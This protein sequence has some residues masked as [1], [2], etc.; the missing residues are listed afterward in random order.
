[1]DTAGKDHVDW[2]KV[3]W[4]RLSNFDESGFPQDCRIILR[5]LKNYGIAK[6]DRPH[7]YRHLTLSSAFGFSND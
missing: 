2:I 6:V 3:T 7:S 5:C 1:M 4:I